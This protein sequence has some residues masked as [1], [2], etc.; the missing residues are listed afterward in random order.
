MERD[1]WQGQKFEMV[2]LS[3]EVGAYCMSQYKRKGP[4]NTADQDFD[5]NV[6]RFKVATTWCASKVSFV[7]EKAKLHQQP[8]EDH[9]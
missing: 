7:K 9:D 6:E 4:V 3:P 5:H 1:N 8:V 2:L